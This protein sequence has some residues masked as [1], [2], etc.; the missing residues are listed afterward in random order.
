MSRDSEAKWFF[1]AKLVLLDVMLT[2]RGGQHVVMPVGLLGFI[3]IMIG[4]A[5][6]CSRCSSWATVTKA[7]YH[8]LAQTCHMMGMLCLFL[9]AGVILRDL[10]ATLNYPFIDFR[11]AAADAAMGF[12]WL[13]WLAFTKAHPTFDWFMGVAY[14]AI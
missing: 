3:G 4:M 14:S 6:L 11:L 1:I 9:G 7:I 8:R 13:Q 12:D 2:I 10:V 5:V